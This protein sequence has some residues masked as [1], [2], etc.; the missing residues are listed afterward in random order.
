MAS[1]GAKGRPGPG[2]VVRFGRG[3][4]GIVFTAAASGTLVFPLDRKKGPGAVEFEP[5][6]VPLDGVGAGRL[7][8]RTIPESMQGPARIA[9]R[10]AP[11]VMD[12]LLRA[13]V[14][15][16]VDTHYRAVHLASPPFV[17]GSTY[18]KYGGR[19]YDS[20]EMG[21][22]AESMLDF[23][24]TSGRFAERFERG[25][26]GFLGVRHVVS[27]NSG[28]S[29][30]LLAVAS[31][32]AGSLGD[33]RLILGDEV[34]TVAC[35]FPT[36]VAPIIQ[37]GLRPVF[38]DIDMGTYNVQA[39]RL[40]ESLS[41]RTKAVFLAHTLGNPFDIGTVRKVCNDRGL[42]LIEDNCDA[43]GSRYGGRLTG[44]F[45]DISTMSFFPA[46]HITTG[47]GG[48]LATSDPA[49][50][51]LIVSFR[52]WG[53][54][55]WCEPGQ[56]N[57]C[58]RR[59]SWKLGDLPE[60]YDHKYTYSNIGYNLKLTEMQAA[61]GVAQLDKLERFIRK[62]RD[63]WKYLHDGLKAYKDIFVLP[64]PARG[65]EPSWFGFLLTLRDDAPFT[66][67]DIVAHLENDRIATRLL[68]AGNLLRHPAYKGIDCRVPF[69]LEN[70]DRAMNRTFWVGVY[71]GLT[72]PMLD[73][74]ID[75]FDRFMKRYKVG[76]STS[77]R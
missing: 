9:G 2:D 15:L 54:D 8:A 3:R 59:F 56:E 74:M 14:S 63:N 1:R 47:E 66:R 61:V 44:T 40:A 72:R 23:W 29:A 36:T 68:F 42:W 70:T 34:V 76:M 11:R 32:T 26:A 71:P 13:L 57:R 21:L 12:A 39:D 48:A 31:L 67:N 24:L 10:A 69:G 62:R 16:S 41:E 18:I 73:H 28:S 4:L 60:G 30:N 33:R 51:K 64:E 75:S 27:V 43:L 6:N 19:V 52:D 5:D 77:P 46:H 22:L 17:A 38:L 20:S 7:W 65:S 53:R 55:C 35:G 37:N 45:G 58:G 25:L 50:K 49:L